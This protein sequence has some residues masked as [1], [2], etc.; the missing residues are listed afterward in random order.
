MKKIRLRPGLITDSWELKL[1]ALGLAV[2]LWAAV[3]SEE[4][5][6]F[7]MRDVPVELR[8]TDQAWV[9]DGAVVPGTVT[10]DVVGPVRELVRLTFAE[11]TMAVPVEDVED[12][13]EFYRPR[14][15]WIEFSE[16]FEN[17]RIEQIQPAALRF[18]FQPIERR[19][20]PV[21]ARLEGDLD[22]SA[23]RVIEPAEVLV[24]GPRN[25]VSVLDSLVVRVPDLAA[26]LDDTVAL[27]LDTAG[28][29]VSAHPHGVSV[30]FE[31]VQE[32]DTAQ[33]ATES[34]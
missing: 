23:R 18:R 6:R 5:T 28:T 9:A 3:R 33:A 24:I 13:L 32:I 11:A 29:G 34:R 4:S 16:R 19:M 31:P 20:I 7:T 17:L 30:Y 26:V 22:S 15:D 1:T 27:P 2:L 10:F 8:L 25:R 21:A 12:T 14:A